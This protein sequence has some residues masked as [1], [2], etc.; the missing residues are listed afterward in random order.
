MGNR[1]M[2]LGVGFRDRVKFR[3]RAGA[4]VMVGAVVKSYGE[5]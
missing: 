1:V 4:R 2:G 5:V 3:V